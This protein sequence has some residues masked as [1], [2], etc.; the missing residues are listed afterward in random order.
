MA[1]RV[2]TQLGAINNPCVR[3]G[4]WVRCFAKGAGNELLG[5]LR[6]DSPLSSCVTVPVPPEE[7]EGTLSPGITLFP[8]TSSMTPVIV[9]MCGQQPQPEGWHS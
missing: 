3:K 5:P 6:G 2:L 9:I 4:M 7:W 1:S 8:G